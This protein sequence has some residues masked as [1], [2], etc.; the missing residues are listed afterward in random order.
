MIICN[1]RKWHL[2]VISEWPS[3]CE[4]ENHLAMVD[5]VRRTEER[6]WHRQNERSMHHWH[7]EGE[8]RQLEKEKNADKERGQR[9]EASG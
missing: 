4:S 5:S 2:L 9:S 3:E 7:L 6:R 1:E 8:E